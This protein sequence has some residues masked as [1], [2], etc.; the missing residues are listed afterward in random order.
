MVVERVVAKA[1]VHVNKELFQSQAHAS[2]RG[3][4]GGAKVASDLLCSCSG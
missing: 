4:G 2:T 1:Q 3:E